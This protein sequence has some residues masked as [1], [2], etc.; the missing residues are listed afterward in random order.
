MS[1]PDPAA[2]GAADRGA[3]LG[4]QAGQEEGAGQAAE[5][6]TDPAAHRATT[7][8]AGVL[9]G[10]R[11]IKAAGE[12]VQVPVAGAVA[13]IANGLDP[14]EVHSRGL[15]RAIAQHRLETF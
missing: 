1:A 4:T 12:H 15:H 11:A 13:V 8:P 5:C 6:R 10:L 2:E 9:V 7:L 3:G 14:L